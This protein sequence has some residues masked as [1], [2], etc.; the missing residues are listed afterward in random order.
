MLLLHPISGL[1]LLCMQKLFSIKRHQ[2]LKH[3]AC[4]CLRMQVTKALQAY[5]T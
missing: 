1:Q 2:L 3:T 5:L 4:L